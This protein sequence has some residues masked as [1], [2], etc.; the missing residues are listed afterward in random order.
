MNHKNKNITY[1][2]YSLN[3]VRDIYKIRGFN[4]NHD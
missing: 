1:Y 3:I 2:N 4:E